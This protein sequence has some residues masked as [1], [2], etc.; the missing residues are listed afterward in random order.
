MRQNLASGKMNY[1]PSRAFL[2]VAIILAILL[3]GIS[4]AEEKVLREGQTFSYYRIY[5]T[6]RAPMLMRYEIQRYGNTMLLKARDSRSEKMLIVA[7]TM[8][9]TAPAA[10]GENLIPPGCKTMPDFS[11]PV[12]QVRCPAVEKG[13]PLI[14]LVQWENG[15][16]LLHLILATVQK[17]DEALL[18]TLQSSIDV[19]PG[20]YYPD[21]QL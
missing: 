6:F 15:A 9:I 1:G 10:T 19:Q 20:F 5:F 21:D 11:Q 12:G 13:V 3:P 18:D 8:R 7:R 14:R 2:A 4:R 16:G 17:E